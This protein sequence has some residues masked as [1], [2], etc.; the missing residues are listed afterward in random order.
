MPLTLDISWPITVL[1]LTLRLGAMFLMTP[2]I[3]AMAMPA[4]MRAMLILVLAVLLTAGFP[5]A[6]VAA[7]MGLAGLMIA[8]FNE[9]T[10][11]AALGL[12]IMVAFA[13]FTVAGRL[14]DIQIGFGLGQSFDPVTRSQVPVLTTLFNMIALLVFFAVNGH[15]ALLR[16]FAFI[17]AN[18]PVGRGALRPEAATEMI[19]HTASMFSLGFALV[20]PVVI[21]LLLVEAG[22]GMLSRSLPQINMFLFGIPIKIVVGLIAL[23]LWMGSSLSVI[24]RIYAGIFQFW[25]GLFR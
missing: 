5:D 24:S 23:A 8:A 21:C 25:E 18:F 1:L 15:H 14:L 7:D 22:L 20:A 17:L 9:L 3:Y 16:G 4:S 6:R 13:T 11:G 2:I 19:K 12:G 10:I